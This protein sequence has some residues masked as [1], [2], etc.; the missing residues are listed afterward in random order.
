MNR[1]DQISWKRIATESAVIVGSILV[2]FAID[3]W[4]DDRIE[5]GAL[6]E[7]LILVEAEL[8]NNLDE[9]DRILETLHEQVVAINRVLAALA[10]DQEDLSEITYMHD[11]GFALTFIAAPEGTESS[12]NALLESSQ[13]RSID[14]DELI[15]ALNKV[16]SRSQWLSNIVR[17]QETL[18]YL[19][20]LPM[21]KRHAVM[22]ELGWMDMLL[23]D[24]KEIADTPAPTFSR[25]EAGM[26][27]RESWNTI[28]NWKVLLLDFRHSWRRYK[29]S[30]QVL[31][32]EVKAELQRL[33]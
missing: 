17:Q 8:V 23:D 10:S 3:A 9:A 22:T 30:S 15:G 28:F 26:R 5:R 24:D 19:N 4:W 16:T 29:E 27:S 14:N 12:I 11:L 1:L 31:L 33:K 6:V 18:Y 13:F 2:A 21:L 20:M 32:D 7:H 25:D